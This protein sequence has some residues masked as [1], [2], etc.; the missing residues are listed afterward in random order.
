MTKKRFHTSLQLKLTLLRSLLRI[1][2][3]VLMY[4]FISHSAVSGMDG[5]QNYMIKVDPQ[6]GDSPIT[7]N[8]DP[9]ALFP[10]FEQEIQETKESFL[11]RSVI[12]TTIIILLSSVCTYFLTKKALTPLQ[13]LTS[14]VSQIQAQ[15][16]S[17]QLPVPNSKDEIAQLTSSF[18]EMLTRLDNAFSTQKQFSANAAH[19]LRT[20]LAVLQTNLEVF[21]KKQK[22]EMIEYRQLFT[23]IKEQ[24]ARLSQLVGTL[25]DMTNLKSV[26]RTDQVSLE[27]LV[28]E[29][30]CDL[31]P[32]AEKA[33]IARGSF[34]QYFKSKKDLLFFILEEN[35]ETMEKKLNRIIKESD[36]EIFNI[37]ISIYDD[38]TSKC[39]DNMNRDIYKRI[40]ENL[41]TND[42]SVF[43]GMEEKKKQD[44]KN[45]KKLIDKSKLKIESDLDFDLIIQILNAITMSSVVRSIKYTS[46]EKAREEF[47][48]KIEFI[49]KGIEK[50]C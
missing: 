26:P 41:K 25:L 21:E 42:E 33:G 35:R 6:D 8:V 37:Y 39:F 46:P 7:F 24:T 11:L 22:P 30:F 31:D 13:K 4:F 40:F 16:L 47:L 44:F 38:M 10:Q 3:C 43:E 9:K 34:Y 29:V 49:K 18:N 1:V 12:A 20:P 19:E 14:E 23:M 27:E 32:I 36:G 28:D 17:T 2:S 45:F 15:N 48:K 50:K 5:L